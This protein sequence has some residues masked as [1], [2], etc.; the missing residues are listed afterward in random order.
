M[1][2]RQV[3]KFLEDLYAKV[4]RQVREILKTID[5]P[6]RVVDI[7][8]VLGTRGVVL[9]V[10]DHVFFRLGLNGTVN[11]LTWSLAGTIS[12]ASAS[13]T[14]RVDVQTGATLATVASICGAGTTHQP[15]LTAQAE[16]SDQVPTS[17]STTQIDDPSWIKA[18]VA[19]TG[20]T[21]EEVGLTLRA[22][23]APR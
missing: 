19:S 5:T 4:D 7:P 1:A 3:I 14:I 6:I 18:I 12:G 20:G 21:L 8:L 10:N 23:V 2:D 16:L 11:I 22:T 9:A 17:W 15:Q 13:G